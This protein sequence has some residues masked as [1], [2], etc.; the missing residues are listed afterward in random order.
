MAAP[1]A[2][3]SGTPI[4]LRRNDGSAGDHR[5]RAIARAWTLS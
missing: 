1:L 5:V 3:T 2:G 4:S